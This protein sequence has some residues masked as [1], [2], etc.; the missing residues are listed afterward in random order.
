MPS[1]FPGAELREAGEGADGFYPVPIHEIAMKKVWYCR[2]LPLIAAGV[3]AAGCGKEE[4]SGGGD[5]SAPADGELNRWVYKVMK[6]NYLWNGEITPSPD[7][8]LGYEEF[9]RSLLK[10]PVPG[11]YSSSGLGLLPSG[12]PHDGTV[13][14]FGSVWS[15]YSYIRSVEPAVRSVSGT[16][17]FGFEFQIYGFRSAGGTLVFAQVLYTVPDSPA[18]RAGLRRG[19]WIMEVDGVAFTDSNY[20]DL[21]RKL[22]P[23]SGSAQAEVTVVPIECTPAGRL[24]VRDDTPRKVRLTAGAV[25]DSPVHLHA[26]HEVGGRR[27]GY[28]VYNGFDRGR[29]PSTF[30]DDY[31][32]RTY[33]DALKKALREMA[34]LD[35]LVLDL[36]YNPGGYALSCQLLASMIAPADRAG[37]VFNRVRDNAGRYTDERFLTLSQMS[38]GNFSG[39]EGV[40][41][42]L[43]RLWVLASSR[44]A[45][46][47]EVLVNGLRGAGVAVHL[48][49]KRTEGKNVGS[50]LFDR[51]TTVGTPYAG[52]VFGG[53]EY[54]IRPICFQNFNARNESD[55]ANGFP[56][57]TDAAGSEAYEAEEL[58]DPVPGEEFRLPP[59][60]DLSEPLLD[61]A[62][63]LI[64]GGETL[65]AVPVRSG[66][67]GSGFRELP[68]SSLD[69]KA[70][71]GYVRTALPGE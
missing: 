1:P 70:A 15:P 25:D 33:D 68:F 31:D 36:R 6:V 46:A 51:T 2:L 64:S 34:P 42:G 32:D 28:L 55:F 59:L 16:R 13:E 62:L 65:S 53:T 29:D 58:P 71:G 3:L 57:G 18:D 45:S 12:E 43:D 69:R 24:I 56:P 5:G 20:A 48:I 35:D 8:S 27:V 52:G 23:G 63:S 21:A 26:V 9:F 44:T 50:Y 7:Y 17:S 49:G 47:S 4:V 22:L 10:R 60:G 37:T 66:R 67:E 11:S 54:Y 40:C 61:R 39:G 19:D 38:E 41:L 14:S 30:E